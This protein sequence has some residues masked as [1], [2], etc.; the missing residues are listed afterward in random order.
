[1]LH[2]FTSEQHNDPERV[3]HVKLCSGIIFPEFELRQP[4]CNCNCNCN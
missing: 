2:V 4:V 3:S 1:V